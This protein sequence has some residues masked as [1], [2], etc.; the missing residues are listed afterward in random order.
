MTARHLAEYRAT[1]A[2]K[3]NVPNGGPVLIDGMRVWLTWEELDVHA[4]DFAAVAQDFAR[5]N[6]ELV[7]AGNVGAAGSVLLSMFALID[8]ATRWFSAHR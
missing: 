7:H 2:G 6:P 1:Y 5:H 4:H 8:H 3:R